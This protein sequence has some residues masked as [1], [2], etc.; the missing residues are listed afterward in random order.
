[1]S[2]L[3][4][5]R[6]RGVDTKRRSPAWPRSGVPAPRAFRKAIG[7][8]LLALVPC[9]VPAADSTNKLTREYDLK[10]AFLFNF[11]QFVEWPPD[12]FPDAGTPITICILGDDPLGSSLD[13]ILQNE[14]VRS[15][16]IVARRYQSVEQMDL[17]HILFI[18]RSETGHLDGTFARLAGKSILTVGETEEFESASGMVRFVVIGNKVRLR[19]NVV[20]AV[21]AKERA[22]ARV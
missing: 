11:T 17:C 22:A 18:S 6:A 13:E 9:S 19:I 21:A 1:M 5:R 16:R 4:N 3:T 20:S 14:M 10:A 12:A 2:I 8:L 15:R 7:M